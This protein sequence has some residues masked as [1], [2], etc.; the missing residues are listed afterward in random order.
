MTGELAA[1]LELHVAASSIRSEPNTKESI[2]VEESIDTTQDS[3][4]PTSD[5]SDDQSLHIE[6]RSE[7]LDSP[8]YRAVAKKFMSTYSSPLEVLTPLFALLRKTEKERHSNLQKWQS[9]APHSIGQVRWMTSHLNAMSALSATNRGL[10][11]QMTADL[12]LANRDFRTSI[13][14]DF[15]SPIAALQ[16]LTDLRNKQI[17]DALPKIMAGLETAMSASQEVV[18]YIEVNLDGNNSK[19]RRRFWTSKA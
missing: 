17:E 3:S 12:K 18:H 15:E 11:N 14:I 16:A 4:L 8:D 1:F 2:E 5:E 6:T 9:A 13:E 10:M 7:F 19:E